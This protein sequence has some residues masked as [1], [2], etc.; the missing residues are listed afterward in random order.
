M[1]N[2]FQFAVCT[3]DEL[4]KNKYASSCPGWAASGFCNNIYEA[5]MQAN[6]YASCGNC[7][8]KNIQKK[9]MKIQRF[10]SHTVISKVIIVLINSSF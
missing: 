9:R 4:D 10:D 2:V 8:G 1:Q 7:Q 5:F 3:E 6:C